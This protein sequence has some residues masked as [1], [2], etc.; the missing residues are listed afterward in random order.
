[1]NNHPNKELE[2]A[3]YLSFLGNKENKHED[4]F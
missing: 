2:L 3:Q 4:Y 1:M